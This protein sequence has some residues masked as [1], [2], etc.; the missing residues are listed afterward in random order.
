VFD[1][2]ESERLLDRVVKSGEYLAGHLAA[3]VTEFPGHATESRGRGLLR[4][5]AVSGSPTQI[6]ARCREKGVLLSVAGDNVVR[7]A[8]PYVVEEAQLDEALSILRGVL[9]DGVGAA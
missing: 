2:M 5:V 7:F 4:G 9:A 8:P 6:V 3:L 1:I